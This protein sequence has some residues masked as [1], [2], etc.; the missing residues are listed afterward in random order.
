[1]YT[2]ETIPKGKNRVL[3]VSDTS[4]G[5]GTRGL[6]AVGGGRAGGKRRAK[7]SPG[8]NPNRLTWEA[9][10]LNLDGSRFCERACARV[11]VRETQR[12]ERGRGEEVEG[13]KGREEKYC[14]DRSS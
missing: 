9:A 5:E 4:L 7:G 13:R 1:M 12:G 6:V 2:V 11:C 3:G 8:I 14:Q 10:V